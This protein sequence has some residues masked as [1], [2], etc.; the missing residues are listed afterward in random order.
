MEFFPTLYNREQTAL[1]IAQ[2]RQMYADKGYCYFAVDTL[3]DQRF[4]GFTGLAWKTFEAPF[5]PC[6]DTGW[7]LAKTAWGKGYAVE[8][9]L[10]CQL[11]AFKELQLQEIKAIAPLLNRRSIRVM[12]RVGMRQEL[13]FK[14]SALALYPAL[15][16]CVCYTISNPSLG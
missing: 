2:M 10:R 1:F 15:E 5:T 9:A 11:Y 13:L 16:P 14:H 8:A 6:V 3:H 7:R 4:I 12:E